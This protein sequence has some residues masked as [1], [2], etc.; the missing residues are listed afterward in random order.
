VALNAMR[1]LDCILQMLGES[2]DDMSDEI[3][4]VVADFCCEDEGEDEE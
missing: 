4:G 2:L 3:K 1:P